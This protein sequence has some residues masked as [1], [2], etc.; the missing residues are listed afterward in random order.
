MD[1]LLKVLLDRI[2]KSFDFFVKK[3]LTIGL[4]WSKKQD[5]RRAP[6]IWFAAGFCEVARVRISR[7]ESRVEWRDGCFES[8]IGSLTSEE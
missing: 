2:K 4:R 3:E 7:P 1:L 6:S 5:S 8:S